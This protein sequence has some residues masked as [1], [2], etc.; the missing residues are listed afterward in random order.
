MLLM[1]WRARYLQLF[2]NLP[3]SNHLLQG[4]APD[5]QT[6]NQLLNISVNDKHAFVETVKELVKRE[7]KYDLH[8]YNILMRFYALVRLLWLV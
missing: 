1:P 2:A 8:T 5:I 7:L 4:I 6:F 3:T